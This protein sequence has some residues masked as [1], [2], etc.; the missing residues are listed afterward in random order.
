VY[1]CVNNAVIKIRYFTNNKMSTL[2]EK[3]GGE[4]NIAAVVDKFYVHVLAD[5]KL[6][7]FFKNTDLN[8]QRQRQ[9]QYMVLGFGGPNKYE[10][11]PLKK[12]HANLGVSQGNFDSA[13][14][15]ME[16]ACHDCKVPADLL[17]EIKKVFYSTQGDVVTVA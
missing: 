5:P 12:V 14:V 6:V 7:D 10:G 8:K 16:Q 13:W 9:T 11:Q 1:L 4:H 15:H 3:L 2:F 17:P